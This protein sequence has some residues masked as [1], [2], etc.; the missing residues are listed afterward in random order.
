M[1]YEGRIIVEDA[2]GCR[3]E[4]HEYRSR[5]SFWPA[6][7]FVLETGEPVNRINFDNYVIATTGEALVRVVG[8]NACS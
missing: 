5:W 4:I 3:F 1:R 8:L 6:R 7:R 2:D